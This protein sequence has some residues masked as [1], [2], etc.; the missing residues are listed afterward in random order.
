MAS[1]TYYG[2]WEY[3]NLYHKVTFDGVNKLIYI[4]PGETDIDVQI[5]LYSSWKEWARVEDYT[6]Y[7]QAFNSVG[8][9]PTQ[10][11]EK[12]DATYFLL[13]GWKIKPYPGSYDLVLTGNIFDADGGS[14]KV[15][16]DIDPLL[17]NNIGIN[18]NTSVIV[19]QL[20]SVVTQSI[21]T[22]DEIVSASLFGAQEDA[23]FNMSGSIVEIHNILQSP[24]TASLT[25]EYALQLQTIE[26]L[27]TSQ[28]LELTNLTNVN[29]SQSNQLGSLID[30][31]A[32]QSL[33]LSLLQGKIIEIWELHG[34]DSTKPLTVTQTARTFG[35]VNQIINTT[36][37]GSLQ[38]TVITRP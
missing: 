12:L 1:G 24:V 37:S 18:T 13:N 14:I 8:G 6:K 19:R 4:N 9:E 22:G 7:L 28:S 25:A 26:D 38:Q 30:T 16:A 10:G 35:S 2:F 15:A 32:S 20:S 17:E 33:Q 5:D 36:G 3:W 27:A 34:L 23:I 29:V 21:L 11:A 31:N